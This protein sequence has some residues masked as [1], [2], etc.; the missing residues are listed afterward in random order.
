MNYRHAYHAGNHADILKH[1]VFSRILS[2]LR[3]KTAPFS[4]LDT[5]A[6]IGWY[7]LMGEAAGKTLEWQSGIAKM[8][9]PFAPEVE[10]LLTSFRAVLS[11]APPL[12]YPGS[13]AIAAHLT[14]HDDRLFFNELHPEDHILLEQNFADDRRVKVTCEDARIAVKSRLPFPLRRGLVLIDPPFEKT[15][16][17]ERTARTLA[18]GLKRMATAVFA[19]WYPV[20]TREFADE[21]VKAIEAVDPPNLLQVELRVRQP[22]LGGGLAGSGLLIV[23]APW[24]LDKEMELLVSAL[25]QRL[26]ESGEGRGS[27]VWLKPRA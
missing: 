15:D 14:R 7:Q 3:E 10:Q 1:V 24:K 26:G 23:N 27:S 9:E 16:E 17:T 19:I 11:A 21:F 6:G 8:H 22:E 25:A 18:D 12:T 13:P 20:T 5:H 4:V 2:H